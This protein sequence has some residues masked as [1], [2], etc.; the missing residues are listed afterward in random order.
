MASILLIEDEAALSRLISWSLLEAGFEVALVE[1]A[2]AAEKKLRAYAP[3][4]IVFN[5][6]L[7]E[8]EKND[9]IAQIRKLRPNARILD[10]SEE[11]TLRV[12]GIV[13]PP[14]GVSLADASLG[15]PFPTE[16]LIE[17]IRD[18][19]ASAV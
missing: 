4:V 1:S 10:V 14:A 15:L 16:R 11:K 6:V 7:P 13:R 17:A 12:Q 9:C 8:D 18:L 3:D 2:S 19:L 5:T